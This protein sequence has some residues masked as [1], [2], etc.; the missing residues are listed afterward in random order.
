MLVSDRLENLRVSLLVVVI[1]F[2]GSA[3]VAAG[4]YVSADPEG[5]RR[6]GSLKRLVVVK[7]ELEKG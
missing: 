1:S 5:V 3:A 6:A 2:S 4:Q 7:E